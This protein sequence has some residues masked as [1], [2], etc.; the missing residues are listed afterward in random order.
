MSA[1]CGAGVP[2]SPTPPPRPARGQDSPHRLPHLGRP[3][4]G[5]PAPCLTGRA[6][7]T[8]APGVHLASFALQEPRSPRRS[9][10]RSPHWPTA[11]PSSPP[12]SRPQPG[13]QTCRTSYSRTG[14]HAAAKICCPGGT[15]RGAPR[16]RVVWPP[17]P[18]TRGERAHAISRIASLW[19]GHR[20]WQRPA[21]RH[22]AQLRACPR[23]RERLGSPCVPLGK[24]E[25][26]TPDDLAGAHC[27]AQRVAHPLRSRRSQGVPC[28][29]RPQGS[30]WP[31]FPQ[32][33]GRESG[34]GGEAGP[35]GQLPRD[36]RPA[37]RGSHVARAVTVSP[38]SPRW[39]RL[40]KRAW[41]A[42]FSGFDEQS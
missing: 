27:C 30:P 38:T 1:V 20:R 17:C 23:L 25:I 24:P 33:A 13:G 18:P 28:P 32:R 29:R 10:R 37:G 11:L 26:M 5:L 39:R 4:E 8:P 42:V 35:H 22:P 6:L 41:G 15:P 12:L 40:S 7:R 31:G 36:L 16:P 2:C 21:P 34:Q 9:P 3:G 19:R 14:C